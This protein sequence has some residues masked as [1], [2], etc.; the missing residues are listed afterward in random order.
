MCLLV[1]AHGTHSDYPLVFAANRDEW[2]K[3]PTAPAHF[4][5]DAPHV[6]A[7]RDLEQR[8]TWFGITRE[9]RFAAVT[10]FRDPGSHRDG[11]PSRGAL[12]SGF[13]TGTEPPSQYLVG[14]T[15]RAHEYNGFNLLV[16]D[17]RSLGYL[18]NRNGLVRELPSGVYGLSNGMLDDP[19]Q[20]VIAAKARL[21][22][23]LREGP[24][25]D[26]L[27]DLLGDRRVVPDA[28][29]P[30]TGVSLE[31]E[32]QLSAMHILA[33]DYGTRSSTALLVSREG[34]VQF[35]ER[36]YDQSGEP[37]GTVRESFAL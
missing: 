24:T 12:V 28:D 16:G 34:R 37:T 19:W 26:G 36:S 7:G 17:L 10:N 15:A 11:A 14:L 3:R 22:A 29:L 2:F 21:T 9:G 8:G 18:S 31:W 27:L 25:V 1:V 5:P 6:L 4:W 30:S 20:K 35:A 32:R 33:G 23:L 13:L